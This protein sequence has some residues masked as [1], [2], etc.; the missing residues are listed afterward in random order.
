M[1][2]PPP[3]R[4]TAAMSD[5]RPLTLVLLLGP[6]GWLIGH[7]VALLLF[8]GGAFLLRHQ[9]VLGLQ[10]GSGPHPF[11]LSP[12]LAGCLAIGAGVSLAGLHRWARFA[13]AAAGF[14]AL[15]PSVAISLGFEPFAGMPVE[16]AVG[17]QGLVA[18][19]VLFAPL[20]PAAGRWCTTGGRDAA[21]RLGRWTYLAAVTWL[22]IFSVTL[23][24]TVPLFMRVFADLGAELPAP[25]RIV[26]DAAELAHLASY[27]LPPIAIALPAPL[28]A[29]MRGPADRYVS[30]A[31]GGIGG[32][33]LAATAFALQL[34]LVEFGM[35]L[36]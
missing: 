33:I 13:S 27:L 21:G 18:G 31:V 4:P 35:R 24:V 36:G 30:W 19:V 6:A 8:S 25:T 12:A 14:L 22:A 7:G 5:R 10:A 3:P 26:L 34:P 23:V 28:V 16:P 32:Q 9:G 15:G 1:H 20:L 17:W 29:S 11:P 2:L